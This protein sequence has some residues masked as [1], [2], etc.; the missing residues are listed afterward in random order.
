SWK[1]YYFISESRGQGPSPETCSLSTEEATHTVSSFNYCD[2][3]EKESYNL[4]GSGR[5]WYGDLFGLQHQYHYAFQLP[6]MLA[7]EEIRAEVKVAARS[8]VASSFTVEADGS[9][10]GSIQCA[11]TNRS[12]YTAIYAFESRKVFSYLPSGNEL[13]FTLSY[14]RP[15]PSSEGWL[16]YICIN[17]RSP[18]SL[19][20]DAL[21]FRDIG[22]AGPGNITEFVL[23]N[24]SSSTV[25]WDVSNPGKA[26]NVPFDLQGN[27]AIFRLASDELREFVAFD[28]NG[29]FPKPEMDGEGL[30]PIGQQNLHGLYRT[31]LVIIAP[32][33]FLPQAEKLAAHRRDHDGLLV[34]VVPQQAVFNEFSSGTPDIC[35]IRNFMKMFYDRCEGGAPLC[36]YL[37]L[38]GDGSYDNRNHTKFNPNCILTY[39][40]ANSL[41]PTQSFTSDDFYGLLDTDESMYSGMLDIG[42]GRLPVSD[43][44]EAAALVDKLTGYDLKENR[45]AWQNRLCFIGDDE[46][47]NIHMRQANELAE[48]VEA[49]YPGYNINKVFLDAYTQKRLATGF[50]YP[51]VTRAINDQVSQ[52]AL[53]VNYTGHGGTSGLA[54][55]QI[56]TKSDIN[57]WNNSDRL[58]LF[59][60]AT[61]EFS[62][63]DDYNHLNDEEKTS[64]GELILLNPEGGGIALFTTTRL[65]YSGPNHV[66][67]E[68]FYELIFEK[69]EQGS[70]PRMGD[71]II[72]AKNNTGSGINKR[73]FTLLGDP[74]MRLVYP[75][76]RVVTDTLNGL[77]AGDLNDTL[78]AFEWVSVSGHIEN[79][80]GQLLDAF[81]GEIY[82]LVFDKEQKVETLANDGDSPWS[83]EARNSTLYSGRAAVVNGR[84]SFGFYVPKDI[85]YAVGKG[86]ISYYALSPESDAQGYHSELMVGG[87]GSIGATDNSHPEIELY[88]NDTLFRDGGITDPHPVLLARVRDNFGINTSGNGIG[89]DITATLD[90]DRI[91]T[92]I[93]NNFFQADINSHNTGSVVYPYRNLEAGTHEIRVKIWDIHNNSSEASI[94]FVVVDSEE[95]VLEQL[96]T[97]PNPF[98]DRTWFNIAHNMPGESLELELRIYSLEGELVR[99]IRIPVKSSGYRLDPLEWDGRSEGGA[100]LG[101]GLYL[102]RVTLSG[103]NGLRATD[104]GKLIIAR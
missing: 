69:D 7:G 85:N 71:V 94:H 77:V 44:A 25:I 18:L 78:S 32:E 27:Q 101:G 90:D 52:G 2:Y 36:R 24:A 97:Y 60:T 17:G 13:S 64:A 70:Y 9:F 14:N 48:F 79:E 15:D 39:Q 1:G 5:E 87:I 66:L 89:H 84:F 53:I 98:T 43:T 68:R 6:E 80:S 12:S 34:E 41:S 59:M 61:C 76:H 35:A 11:A 28:A 81:N 8:N 88:M 49:N 38:F 75:T 40:S 19:R 30:G 54:H 47:A 10:L 29:S 92:L 21:A 57:A 73:N 99:L 31:D 56:L 83:F 55:E 33:E 45:G 100:M 104:T 95:M 23:N 51:E 96:F 62:R 22:S 86:K 58:P 93:L 102:Y 26:L 4:I 46:D 65:V 72:Y 50:S 42:I 20:G 16:N 74:S 63:Y 91:N 103:N 37:L 67:N 82:P 3:I